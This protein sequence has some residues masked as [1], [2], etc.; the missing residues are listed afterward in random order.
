MLAAL[1]EIAKRAYSSR[2]TVQASYDIA[3]A[4][5][6]NNVL[7]DFVECGVGAGANAAAMALAIERMRNYGVCKAELMCETNPAGFE[8]LDNGS[9]RVHLFDS[10]TG[11]PQAGPEDVEFLKAGHK[12]G[13]SA[14]SRAQVE[15]NLKEWGLPLELFVFH[16]GDFAETTPWIGGDLSR[17]AVLRL[18]GDLY[19]STRV[20]I[21]HLY[22]LVSKGGWVIV[23]D[24][25]LS[26]ARKAVLDYMKDQF[27]PV[28][29]GG[30]NGADQ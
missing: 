5:I 12:P 20:C 8:P 14:H 16:E 4:A 6:D 26:G 19:E 29:F 28:Y 30:Q 25:D 23:D 18:D 2:E 15:A 24:W 3:R 10:F 9:R 1:E 21:E 17:I 11:I 7:G 22:P 13:L 27:G